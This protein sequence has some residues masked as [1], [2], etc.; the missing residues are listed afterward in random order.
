MENVEI[1]TIRKGDKRFDVSRYDSRFNNQDRLKG[2]I[3]NG[4]FIG[5]IYHVDRFNGLRDV[6]T[7]AV[8]SAGIHSDGMPTLK[9][10][11]SWAMKTYSP[12][13]IVS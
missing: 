4:L 1:V 2:I 10:A 6:R 3:V 7:W 5:I 8:T 11:K 9:A 12:L 13:E